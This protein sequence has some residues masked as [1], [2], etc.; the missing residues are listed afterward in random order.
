[1]RS[2]DEKRDPRDS[3]L[4]AVIPMLVVLAIA[5]TA[6]WYF[7]L[8]STPEKAVDGYMLALSRMDLAGGRRWMSADLQEKLGVANASADPVAFGRET[9]DTG[10]S[11]R[12]GAVQIDG[13]TA[14]VAVTTRQRQTV[15][16]QLRLSADE[17]HFVLV[18]V[19]GIWLV[20]KQVMPDGQEFLTHDHAEH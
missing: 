4:M 12:I 7:L 9:V 10:M 13:D 2:S 11:Y 16:G 14:T 8:R 20:D 6:G 5:A 17:A 1:M 19:G 15:S 18:K 3:P